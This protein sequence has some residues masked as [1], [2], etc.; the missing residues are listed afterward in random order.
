MTKHDWIWVAIRV[1]GIYLLVQAII[2]IPSLI[3]SAFGVYQFYDFGAHGTTD[4]D[5]VSR[6]LHRELGTQL[7]SSLSRLIICGGAGFYFIKGGTFLF[8]LICQP[9]TH[10]T[11]KHEV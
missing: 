5:H 6:L 9:D 10:D 1:F 4:L 7:V 8:R 3:S 2:A 11:D